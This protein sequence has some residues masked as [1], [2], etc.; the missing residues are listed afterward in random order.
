RCGQCATVCPSGAR[1]LK[2]REGVDLTKL[3]DALLDDYNLKA[4]YRFRNNMIK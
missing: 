2:Q 4:E 1:K 3:P